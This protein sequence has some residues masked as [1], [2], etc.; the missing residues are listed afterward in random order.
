M[1]AMRRRIRDALVGF[2]IVGAAVGFLGT[3]LWM[4]GVQIGSNVWNVTAKFSDASGLAK[5]SP[6]T[7]RGIV[8]GSVSK[9]K[10][11]PFA[12][13]ATLEINEGDLRLPM[14]VSANITKA[15]L[16]GGNAQVALISHG[17]FIK[18]NSPPPLSPKCAEEFVLCHGSTIPGEPAGSISTVAK[19]FDR[20]LKQAEKKEL[21][22]NIDDLIIQLKKELEGAVPIINNLTDATSHINNVVSALDNPK[23]IQE[24]KD[25]VSTARSLTAKID[26]V[27]QDLETLTADP[28]FMNAVRSVTIGLGEFFSELYPSQTALNND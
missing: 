15:S 4:K 19:T 12:V 3:H 6:V 17:K 11:T 1:T 7:Y 13:L 23:T 25:T 22:K 5:L 8:I 9:I 18:P 27:G 24:L 10:I 20:I 28:K 2:S 21:V 16:L 14:P 26:A